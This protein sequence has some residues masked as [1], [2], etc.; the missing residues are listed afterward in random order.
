MWSAVIP[1]L[2]LSLL[3]LIGITIAFLLTRD[4]LVSRIFANVTRPLLL[5]FLIALVV[6]LVPMILLPVG[7]AY[8]IESFRL[9]GEALL[10]GE[11]VYTSAAT[12]RHPYFPLQ[13]YAVGTATYLSRT[14]SLPFVVW[15][16]LPA[17]LADVCISVLIYISF[18][19]WGR[20]ETISLSWALLYALNPIAILVSA[21]HGQF[22]SISVLLLLMAWYAW[23]FGAHIKRSAVFL[24]FAALNKSWPIVFLPIAFIRLT[25]NRQRLIY[26]L[27]A[28]SI[29]AIFTAAYVILFS[30]DPTPMLRRALT[31]SGVAGYWGAS[32][33]IYLLGNPFFDTA[34]IW[35][36][37]LSFQRILI[38][39]VGLLTLWLTRRQSAL[40]ALLT[41][42]LAIFAVTLGVGIQWLLWPLA[43]AVL[44]SERRWLQWYTIAGT[45]MMFVHLY[46]LHMY[47]WAGEL[48]GT[49]QANILVRISSLPVWIITVS[50]AVSRIR[51]VEGSPNPK[52]P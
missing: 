2:S 30:S 1:A 38:L 42:I 12:G 20:S 49:D 43:F 34:Q 15:L 8:D 25:N 24:G 48:L 36:A 18:R 31:H 35:P 39:L 32:L 7:A 19:K 37:V 50:W 45:F 52:R 23:H 6:R 22:D 27:F 46:G 28:L 44:A 41:I 13:M 40:D 17:V 51:H 5:L 26:T 10:N 4:H 47:P 14:T 29:P 11:D 3:W 33:I 16:K 21:Y 9:V